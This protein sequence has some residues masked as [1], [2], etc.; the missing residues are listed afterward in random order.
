MTNYATKNC[1]VTPDISLMKKMASISGTIPSR[2]MELVDNAID[3]R[4]PGK[5]LVVEVKV[6]K[7]GNKQ[8]IEVNDN[9]AGMTELVARSFFRLGES[10]KVG[11][12]KIGKFG[13]GSKVAIL[14][15]GNTCKIDTSPYNLPYSIDIN[16]DIQKFKNWKIDYK[17]RDDV[18]Q[19]HG[20]K[21]K[22]EN[23]TIRIGNIKRFC[24]RVHEQFS[25]AYKHFI[26]NGEVEILVNG[27]A[28]S[29]IQVD[30]IPELYKKFDF[31]LRSGKRVHGW[32]GAMK[33]AGQNWR[34]G[35][36]LIN[37]GRIIKANDFLTRQAHTSL[38]RLTG[39]IHLDDFATDVHKTDFLRD[40]DDFQEM[41]VMLIEHELAELITKITRL[42]NREVF[43]KY[44]NDMQDVSKILNRVV[45]S[46][47]FL[48]HIDIEDGIFKKLKKKAEQNKER[49]EQTKNKEQEESPL[50]IFNELDSIF[51]DKTSV[52]EPENEKKEENQELPENEEP[53][54]RRDVGL[55]IEE[56]IGISAGMEQPSRRWVSDEFDEGIRLQVEVNLDHPTYQ[57]DDETSI[58][59]YMKNAVLESV[60]EFILTEEKN[61]NG[62][63][64]DE[65]ERFNRLKDMLIRY[66]LSV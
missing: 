16:F 35:F 36:D 56:P 24:E 32:A 50:D 25:K 66:S 31:K 46:Y 12:N 43:T 44:Q 21:I 26:E 13:L 57:M 20:T 11:K 60:A 9:G 17:L 18:E 7:R 42:T 33:K 1:D 38:A 55:I 19:K 30:L 39:E 4:I 5:K 40:N 28:V 23:V 65:I 34:F 54:R 8:Y 14:G 63:I 52:Q 45:R 29:T 10:Q 61:Q 15:I 47:E 49:K 27:E 41:Q 59:V 53:K 62:F 58:A 48:S 3:A 51:D 2:L 22:I 37:N 6:V 64:E